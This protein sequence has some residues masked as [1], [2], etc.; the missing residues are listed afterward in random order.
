MM[1]KMTN[2]CYRMGGGGGDQMAKNSVTKEKH[3]YI[4][5]Y[6]ILYQY[7]IILFIYHIMV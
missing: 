3:L 2:I 1:L 6:H 4:Y 5:I 7:T